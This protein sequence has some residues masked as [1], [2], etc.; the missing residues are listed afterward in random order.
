[1]YLFLWLSSL[2]YILGMYLLP[3]DANISEVSEYDPY[4][5]VRAPGKLCFF[6]WRWRW[7]KCH[8]LLQMTLLMA[9]AADIS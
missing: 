8:L 1:M 6:S 5:K 9:R 2:G 4:R 7:F 3:W